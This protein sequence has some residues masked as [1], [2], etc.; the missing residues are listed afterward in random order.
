MR[1]ASRVL[2]LVLEWFLIL[3]MIALTIVVVYAVVTRKLGASLSWY[4]EIA[5]IQLCWITYYG[6]ALAALKRKHIG[7]DG[8][9]LSLPH[10]LRAAGIVVAEVLVIGFFALLAWSGWQVLLI[11][12]GM[13]L[14][15]LTFVPVQLT[16]SVIP[17]GA[18][19]FIIASLLSLPHY[20][21][22][23]MAGRSFEHPEIV[24]ETTPSKKV[25]T[26]P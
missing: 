15:S 23:T 1:T 25:E 5:A 9:L 21:R 20:W 7:F 8:F 16:Q 24:P 26:R 2:A 4:D 6:A 13:N 11:L 10:G 3:Q 14:I 18:L 19:L 12:E 17:I 22:E